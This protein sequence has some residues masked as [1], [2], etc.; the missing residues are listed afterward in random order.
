MPMS[1]SS[2][3]EILIFFL[4]ALAAFPLVSGRGKSK[5]AM[6]SAITKTATVKNKVWYV[7]PALLKKIMTIGS[8]N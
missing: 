7:M 1:R 3:G 2:A 6:V 8:T 4:A 5:M